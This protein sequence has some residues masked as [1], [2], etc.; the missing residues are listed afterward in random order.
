MNI[1]IKGYKLE[2]FG[3]TLDLINLFL[4]F[5]IGIF[6]GNLVL[7]NCL[8]V[9]I[10]EL[11]YEVSEFFAN[12]INIE[13]NCNNQVNRNFN[14]YASLVENKGGEIPLPEN[15]LDFFYAN[16]FKPDCCFKPQQYSSGSGC[17]CISVEQ[18]K[19]LNERGG[20]NIP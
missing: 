17:P 5:L 13:S 16:N 20:N 8:K 18:M 10:N 11:F 7:C 4:G 19:Y 3:I 15:E 6:I 14:M 12:N 1:N 9:P 2:V